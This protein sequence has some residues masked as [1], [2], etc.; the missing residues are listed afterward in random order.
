[1]RHQLEEQL[2]QT[3]ARVQVS[4]SPAAYN[5]D[6]FGVIAILLSELQQ[7]DLQAVF[8]IEK[9]AHLPS[10]GFVK[11][12][13]GEI[14]EQLAIPADSHLL[15]AVDELSLEGGV[16]FADVQLFIS[17]QGM[18]KDLRQKMIFMIKES[19]SLGFLLVVVTVLVLRPIFVRPIRRLNQL[20]LAIANNETAPRSTPSGS[21]EIIT[22]TESL[23]R[24]QDSIQE[25]MADL[26]QSKARVRKLIDSMP[27]VLI[28][29]S[30]E[31]IITQ[32][33]V[34]A[35][36]RT[37]IAGQDAVGQGLDEVVPFL[38]LDL[39]WINQAIDQK[40]EIVDRKH[41]CQQNGEIRYDDVTIYPLLGSD[42]KEAVV[43]L[44]DVTEKIRLEE[45]MV[46]NEKMM[47]VGGLAAGMAHEI[48]NP[49]GIMVQ[50]VQ[51]IERRVEPDRPR[52]IKIADEC[53]VDMARVYEYFEKQKI[54]SMLTDIHTAGV[55]AA[56]IVSNMLKFSRRSESSLVMSSVPELIDQSIE[57]ATSDY[58]LKKKFDFRHIMLVKNYAPNLP[59]ARVMVTEFE[60]VILNLLKNSAQ[61]MAEQVDRSDEPSITIDVSAMDQS[62]T[63]AIKDNGP[64]M[65][66]EVQSRIFEPFFTTKKVG[67]GTGLGL[68][69]S[70]MIITNNHKGHLEVESVEGQGTTFVI[71]LPL[72][73]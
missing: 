21:V 12:K 15:Y 43:R 52:N 38:G 29:V 44:D 60:Q 66:K 31:G 69:V 56:S 71:T 37:G 6:R 9:E 53:Q 40:K 36:K 7:P 42:E 22:L 55:R 18:E 64:G 70:Y 41:L 10:Y 54:I 72:E 58:D 51:N 73:S 61:A 46:Q 59:L 48:N 17:T 23:Y 50:A 28:G 32:W 1:M 35:E 39:K 13:E 33:N 25:K 47:S 11:N 26:R 65:S 16:P 62:M 14:V 68:S 30:A 45:M 19:F 4:V 20:A 27:S 5:L 8:I 3:L 67:S 2:E 63:I 24:M 34:Q 49:L 57:L